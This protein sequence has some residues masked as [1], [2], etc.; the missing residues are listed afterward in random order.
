[1]LKLYTWLYTAC[2]LFS[3]LPANSQSRYF[4]HS[5]GAGIFTAS[6]HFA[7]G[8]VYSPRFNFGVLSRRSA[9]AI[10]T[11]LALGSSLRASYNRYSGGNSTSFFMADVPILV[12]YNYG[13]FATSGSHSR[14]GIFTGAGYGFHNGSR[15]MENMDEEENDSDQVHVSGPVLTT[16]CRFMIGRT[17]LGLHFSYLFNSNHYNPDINGIGSA[18]LSYNIHSSRRGI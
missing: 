8:I 4:A 10:G 15:V 17:S 1:M 12:T 18:G 11:Q 2:L 14:L 6:S 9:F 7:G 16:G 3:I 13:N 5:V